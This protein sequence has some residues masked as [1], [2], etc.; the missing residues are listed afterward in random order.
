MGWAHGQG[1]SAGALQVL[2]ENEPALG[3]YRSL[4]FGRLAYRYHYRVRA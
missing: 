1:A 3:L 2:A 4:G